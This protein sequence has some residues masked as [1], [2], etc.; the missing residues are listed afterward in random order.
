MIYYSS[1]STVATAAALDSIPFSCPNSSYFL[2]S[3]THAG[4]QAAARSRTRRTSS[5]RLAVAAAAAINNV[6]V[7]LCLCVLRLVST[8]VMRTPMTH[9]GEAARNKRSCQRGVLQVIILSHNNEHHSP[10]SDLNLSPCWPLLA[11]FSSVRRL[12]WAAGLP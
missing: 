3:E 1:Q 7:T 10:T 6:G 11:A 4:R 8:L 2:R 5:V 9:R 12:P